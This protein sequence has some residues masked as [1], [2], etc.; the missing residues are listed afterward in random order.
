MEQRKLGWGL[1][2]A[3][4]LAAPAAADREILVGVVVSDGADAYREAG[5]GVLASLRNSHSVYFVDLGQDGSKQDVRRLVGRKPDVLVAVGTLAVQHV[6]AVDGTLPMV[7]A[8]VLDPPS[9]GLPGP[10]DRSEQPVT[11]V[12]MAVSIED[13]FDWIRENVPG[14]HRVGVLHDPRNSEDLIL[15]AHAVAA[16]RGFELVPQVVRHP[17]ETLGQ[18]RV[19][20]A[21]VDVLWSVSDRSVLTASNARALVLLCL[22]SRKPFIAPSRGYVRAG[23]LAAVAADPYSVGRRAGEMALAI[24]AGSEPSELPPEAPP[25]HSVFLNRATA[26]RLGIQLS[27]RVLGEAQKVYP[28]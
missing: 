20:L 19:L 23:A 10:D 3:L 4:L 24:T 11:G 17:G 18:A 13:Q 2:A 28:E 1:L 6:R 12:S 14:A 16:Q 7:Y 27:Q 15:R 5:D 22:R 9:L 21:R 26:K 8:M 25:G